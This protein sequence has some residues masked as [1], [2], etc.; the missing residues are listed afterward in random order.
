M[1]EPFSIEYKDEWYSVSVDMPMGKAGRKPESSTLTITNVLT[2]DVVIS[3]VQQWDLNDLEKVKNDNLE[4][5]A[6]SSYF[7]LMAG[8][9]KEMWEE[10]RHEKLKP[11]SITYL[12]EDI[13]EE[14]E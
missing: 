1:V 11:G 10:I 3:K 6:Q 5:F 2:G 14:K 7:D 9:F 13:E 8:F 12:G 4:C